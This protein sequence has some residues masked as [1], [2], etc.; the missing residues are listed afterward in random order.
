MKTNLKPYN[1]SLYTPSQ[2]PL[3]TGDLCIL[4]DSPRGYIIEILGF[5]GFFVE[6][7]FLDGNIKN[8]QTYEKNSLIQTGKTAEDLIKLYQPTDLEFSKNLETERS[9]PDFSKVKKTYKSKGGVKKPKKT[10]KD[11]T[12]EQ[13]RVMM[14]FMEKQLNELTKGV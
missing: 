14:R 8:I 2:K 13:K 10:V 3:K 5:S 7:K 1:S 9:F 11:L 6:C 4:L 12:K